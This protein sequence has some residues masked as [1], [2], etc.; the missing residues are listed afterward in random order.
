MK[1]NRKT[2]DDIRSQ[3]LVKLQAQTART[4]RQIEEKP[5]PKAL[6]KQ[7]IRMVLEQEKRFTEKLSRGEWSKL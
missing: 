5:W 2:L 4:L 7:S 3:T 1:P 6:I